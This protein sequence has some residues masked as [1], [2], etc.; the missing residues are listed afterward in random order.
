MLL[1]KTMQAVRSEPY[2][3]GSVVK[4]MKEIPQLESV[5]NRVKS[6]TK[7]YEEI[8]QGMQSIADATVVHITNHMYTGSK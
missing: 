6:G 5:M 3:H 2:I 1:K 4:I 7:T 8:T